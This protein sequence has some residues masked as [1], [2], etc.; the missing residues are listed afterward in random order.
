ME[1]IVYNGPNYYVCKKFNDCKK[2]RADWITMFILC[3]GLVSINNY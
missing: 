1:E 3:G 2:P